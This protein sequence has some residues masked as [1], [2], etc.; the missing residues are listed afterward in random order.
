MKRILLALIALAAF[1]SPNDQP[2]TVMVT[3]HAK[4]GAEAELQRVLTRHWTTARDLKLVL[5]TPHMSLRGVE[6]G[7][8]YFVEIFAWRDASTPDHAPAAIQSIWAEMNKLVEGRGV[9]IAVVTPY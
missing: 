7:A 3:C 9:E 1:A 6:N 8:T 2:E 4:P 5:D